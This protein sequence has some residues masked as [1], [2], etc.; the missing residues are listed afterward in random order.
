MKFKNAVLA[1]DPDGNW[2]GLYIDGKLVAE[3]HRLDLWTVL[4]ALG[5]ELG[6]QQATF[7]GSVGHKCPQELKDVP[8]YREGRTKTTDSALDNYP[9]ACRIAHMNSILTPAA[10]LEAQT[11]AD[12][13]ADAACEALVKAEEAV[14]EAMFHGT[15]PEKMQVLRDTLVKAVVA[16]G[17]AMR[18][19]RAAING[20][21]AACGMADEE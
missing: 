20:Y 1:S 21:N 8:A 17:E 16:R 3:G 10:A 11:V 6:S 18:A 15:T 13:A 12:K 7:D 4:K 19:Y 14:E 2:E 9:P 5:V